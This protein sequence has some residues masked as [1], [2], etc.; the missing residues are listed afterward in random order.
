[1][2]MYMQ[3]FAG[4]DIESQNLVAK[5]LNVLKRGAA[6]VAFTATLLAPASAQSGYTYNTDYTYTLRGETFRANITLYC[7]GIRY[8][9]Y[10]TTG[11]LRVL[12]QSCAANPFQGNCTI[13]PAITG[14]KL[15]AI[16]KLNED[17][18]R[19]QRIPIPRE[20]AMHNFCVGGIRISL[21]DRMYKRF[22]VVDVNPC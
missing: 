13:Q 5:A 16:Y 7:D 21:P 10:F 17:T 3:R 19:A 8:G 4:K 11:C 20:W 6:P 14:A 2:M 15:N 12:P 18:G 1:M 22:N 9:K